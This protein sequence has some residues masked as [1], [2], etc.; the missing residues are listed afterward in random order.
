MIGI[1]VVD[2]L[3]LYKHHGSLYTRR[4]NIDEIEEDVHAGMLGMLCTMFMI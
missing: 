4:F 1:A 3:Y 2:Q